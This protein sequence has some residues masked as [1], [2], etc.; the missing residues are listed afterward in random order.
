MKRL[1][2]LALPVAFLACT[3]TTPLEP[4][5]DIKP[6]FAA[7]DRGGPRPSRGDVMGATPDIVNAEWVTGVSQDG[8]AKGQSIAMTDFAYYSF[9]NWWDHKLSDVIKIQASFLAGAGAV[10]SGGSPRFSLLIDIDGDLSSHEVTDEAVIFLDPAH[11]TNSAKDGWRES[12]FTGDRTDCSIYVSSIAAPFVSD[13]A[14][15]AWSK[16]LAAFPTARVWF[17]FVIQDA[18]TGTNYV[19]RIKLDNAFFT[20]AP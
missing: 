10:N 1:A 7:D 6:A 2:L 16:V 12:D 17:M 14:G 3:E 19:D 13:A 11:C 9:R 15:T 20:S 18:S 8:G 5:N 4:R